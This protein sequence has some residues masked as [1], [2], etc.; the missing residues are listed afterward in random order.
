MFLNQKLA[1]VACLFVLGNTYVEAAPKKK[2]SSSKET[3]SSVNIQ[4]VSDVLTEFLDASKNPENKVPFYA[5]RLKALLH[6]EAKYAKLCAD[7]TEISSYNNPSKARMVGLKLLKHRG[8]LPA[9]IKNKL[10]SRGVD[11]LLKAI[12][13]RLQ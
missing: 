13:S 8:V 11:S 10:E 2:E 9:D 6:K 1:L 3:K 5:N 7:L 4:E 12:E